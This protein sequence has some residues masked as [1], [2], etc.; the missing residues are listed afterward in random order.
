MAS[1]ADKHS[2]LDDTERN[3]TLLQGYEWCE[4]MRRFGPTICANPTCPAFLLLDTPAG[5]THWQWLGDNAARFADLGITAVWIPPPTK[6]ANTDSTGF[7]V[8]DLWDLGE[9]ARQGQEGE[10]KRTKYG[11]REQ[12]EEAMSK[13]RKEGISVIVDAVLN[14]RMGADDK[15]TFRVQQVDDNDRTKNIGEERDIEGWTKFEF[16][17]RNGKHSD[18]KMDFNHFTGVDYDAKTGDKGV[19]RILG[20]NKSF[21]DDVDGEKGGYDYLMGADVDHAHPDVAGDIINW[22]K[23]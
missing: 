12:L 14:H 20:K 23:W 22:G 9:F 2:S 19:F 13:L 4:C 1:A 10:E 8:Y 7:D 21:A 11:T 15:E 17:G 18:F 3:Y 5:G 6:A 16:K